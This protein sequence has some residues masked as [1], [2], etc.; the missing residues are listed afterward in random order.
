MLLYTIFAWKIFF[1]DS[2][3][4]HETPL[5]TYIILKREPYFLRTTLFLSRENNLANF[6]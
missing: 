4:L 2:L 1:L 3:F 5:V 6:G